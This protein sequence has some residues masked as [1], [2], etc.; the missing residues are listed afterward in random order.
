MIA[1]TTLLFNWKNEIE[2]HQA[3]LTPEKREQYEQ[4]FAKRQDYLKKLDA[5]GGRLLVGPD[6]SGAYGVPG[7]A[8]H[9]EMQH[10]KNAAISNYTI[11]KAA[12]SNMAEMYGESDNWGTI[13]EGSE[14][15]L[16]IL[17]ANPLESINNSQLIEQVITQGQIITPGEI[18]K[19]IVELQK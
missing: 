17:G 12:C 15:D 18:R 14:S 1:P 10:F 9:V 8:Y 11:L 13:T 5:A 16:L 4:Q 2:K 3:A 7:F 19:K 6:A